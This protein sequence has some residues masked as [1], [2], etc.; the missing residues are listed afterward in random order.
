MNSKEYLKQAYRLN[1]LINSNL[2]EVDGL[3]LLSK[4][5]T[6]VR[7]DKERVQGGAL[8]GGSFENTIA[9]IADLEREINDEID[10]FVDLKR[11]IRTA[12]NLIANRNE[13]LLLRL[14]YIEFMT[15]DEI[16][17]HMGCE[18]TRMFTIHA[19]ALKNFQIPDESELK[20]IEV[21]LPSMI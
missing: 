19:N 12:I 6:V 17:G 5:I 21:D 20:G 7:Y 18:R 4:G 11:D 2:R 9:K 16:Q 8:P 1:D 13:L 10:S 14:R 15:W 3:K